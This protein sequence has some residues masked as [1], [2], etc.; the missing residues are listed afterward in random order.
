MAE[1]DALKGDPEIQS[2]TQD[3]DP[4]NAPTTKD[5][6]GNVGDGTGEGA[7]TGDATGTNPHTG[8]PDL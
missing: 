6:D 2:G 8:N 5:D 4:V 1:D 3:P 7:A